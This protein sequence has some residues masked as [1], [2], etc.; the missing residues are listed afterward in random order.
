MDVQK[1]RRQGWL[2]LLATLLSFSPVF[3]QNNT[4]AQFLQME[5]GSRAQALGG[6]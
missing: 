1:I 4:G 5:I 3:T 6:A 2:I